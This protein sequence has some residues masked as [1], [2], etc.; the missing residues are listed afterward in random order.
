MKRRS[1]PRRSRRLSDV[2]ERGLVGRLEQLLP[3]EPRWVVVGRGDDD[4][5]AIDCGGT[6]LLL[7][8]C[9]VQDEGRHFRREWIDPHTLG[10]R[11]AAVNLSDI[12]AMGGEP[13]AALVSLLLPRELELSWFD[14]IMRGLG[15]RLNEFGAALV[16]GNLS[17]SAQRITVDVALLGRVT[18]RHL[19]R[20]RGARPGDRI[21][22]SGWPG[23][24][25][26]GLELLARG[27]RRGSLQRGF[28]D[29]EPRVAAGRL[30]AAH[31]VTSM[32]DVSDGL[33]T[34]LLSLCDASGVD[35]EVDASRLP[36]S[37]A[38]L[39]AAM[40]MR[41]SAGN[42]A[43]RTARSAPGASQRSRPGRG[44]AASPARHDAWR[45]VMQGGE[46]YELVCT[47][48]A[49]RVPALARALRARLR[50]PLTDIGVILPAR[51]GRWLI[52]AGRRERLSAQG[53]DHFSDRST[54]ARPAS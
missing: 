21:L 35:A 4:A 51:S 2:G 37:T 50:L 29:P 1:S 40:R 5:A 42:S 17:R 41:G 19:I 28:L 36:V 26:A 47:A 6:D 14:G 48:P 49:R 27:V 39:R 54:R 46:A 24:S 34:D 53:Y 8:T 43:G 7:L 16:G 25:A 45:W 15:E 3:T 38:L 23:E 11:A 52:R 20:R 30:L 10:R 13:R 18:R 9:D 12:A 22:V 44:G 32:I 31:G 33:A